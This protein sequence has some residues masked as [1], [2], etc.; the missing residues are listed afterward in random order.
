MKQDE[1][2]GDLE[3]IVTIGLGGKS[4]NNWKTN[5]K[6]SWKWRRLCKNYRNPISK[7]DVGQTNCENKRKTCKTHVSTTI[8]GKAWSMDLL[9][10][11]N[12]HYRRECGGC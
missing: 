10:R 11:T 5:K 12:N 2:D 6:Q 9:L 8:G 3:F 1:S 7:F 4:L